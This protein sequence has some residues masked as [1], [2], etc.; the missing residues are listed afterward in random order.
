MITALKA[1][2]GLALQDL[3]HGAYDLMDTL[4]LPAPARVYL[5]DHLG[6]AE[7]RLSLGGSEKIQ[8]SALLGAFK[9]AVEL[10]QK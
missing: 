9:V 6:Q 1:E 3:I 4:V 2:K 7:H 8:L 5:L 10:S